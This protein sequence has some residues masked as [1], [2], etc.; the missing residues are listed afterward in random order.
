MRGCPPRTRAGASATSWRASAS[1][2]SR[3]RPSLPSTR[4]RSARRSFGALLFSM[5]E[6]DVPFPNM[7][8]GVW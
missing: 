3:R 2:A 5:P 6:K 8:L 7:L 4:R 1:A